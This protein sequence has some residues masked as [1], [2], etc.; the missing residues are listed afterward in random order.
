MTD[1]DPIVPEPEG[2]DHRCR[3]GYRLGIGL[4]GGRADYLGTELEELPV[5]A[6][7]RPFVPEALA[8]V[9]H[10]DGFGVTPHTVHERPYDRGRHL[11]TEGDIP[12]SLVF[13]VV[14]LLHDPGAGPEDEEFRILEDRGLDLPEPESMSYSSENILV[15]PSLLKLVRQEIPRSTG[16]LYHT[17]TDSRAVLN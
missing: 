12:V 4:G 10:L 17:T 16:T 5:S 9:E 11:R 14:E 3:H 13:E 8:E 1:A 7:L 15:G 6:G 2:F